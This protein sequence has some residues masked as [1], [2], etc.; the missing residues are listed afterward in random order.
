MDRFKTIN[1]LVEGERPTSLTMVEMEAINEKFFNEYMIQ[2]PWKNYINLVG[3]S[4]VKIQERNSTPMGSNP[5]DSLCLSVGLS[6]KL[7]KHLKLPEVYMGVRVF[8]NKI[9]KIRPL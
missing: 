3:I 9:G 4:T 7:P 5:D 6:K 1:E 8:V 2:E